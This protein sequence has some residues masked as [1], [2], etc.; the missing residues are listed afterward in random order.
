MSVLTFTFTH[1]V[2][3]TGAHFMAPLHVILYGHG[4]TTYTST[5]KSTVLH[6]IMM[7]RNSKRS[8]A[9]SRANPLFHPVSDAS[10]I[11][12]I[13]SSSMVDVSKLIGLTASDLIQLVSSDLIRLT[14]FNSIRLTVFKLI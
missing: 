2:K 5:A 14:V 1:L 4:I 3:V 7:V 8:V 9:T 10:F 13:G 6:G 11:I 12:G